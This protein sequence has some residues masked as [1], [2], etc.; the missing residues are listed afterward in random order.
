MSNLIPVGSNLVY[1]SEVFLILFVITVSK[2]KSSN[3][4]DM[5][6]L[7]FGAL[8]FFYKVCTP[9]MVRFSLVV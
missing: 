1:V 7:H 9:K 4:I 5:F 6:S 2:I 8:G 3:L